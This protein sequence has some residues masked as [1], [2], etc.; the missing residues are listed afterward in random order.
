VA[1]AKANLETAR[2]NLKYSRI[3]APISGRIALSAVTR[4]RWSRPTRPRR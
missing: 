3:E 2:I 4:V 1:V